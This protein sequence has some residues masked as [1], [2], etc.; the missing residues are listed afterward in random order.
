[1]ATSDNIVL[2]AGEILLSTTL[3]DSL[4]ADTTAKGGSWGGSWVNLGYTGG[5]TSQISAE[6]HNVE[7]DQSTVEVR[8]FI[9]KQEVKIEAMLKEATLTNLKYAL[10]WGTLSTTGSTQVLQLGDN[11]ATTE[12]SVGLEGQ[13]PNTS[14][15][16]RRVQIYRAVPEADVEMV[17]SRGEESIWKMT[18]KVLL[19]EAGSAGD[20]LMQIRDYIA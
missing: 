8:S 15:A 17:M 2:G 1:M 4:P 19:Y 18:F 13:S 11:P 9:T 3:A 20:D 12:Y 10:G 6:R 14:A 16:F 7:V 5:V